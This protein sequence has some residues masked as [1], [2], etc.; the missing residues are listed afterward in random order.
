MKK[1]ILLFLMITSILSCKKENTLVRKKKTSNISFHDT[2]LRLNN[3][4]RSTTKEIYLTEN[5]AKHTLYKYFKNK[6][7]LIESELKGD[8]SELELPEYKRKKSIDFV[9]FF[10][11]NLNGKIKND[12]IISYY[13]CEPY[14]N[15]HCVQPHKAVI[16]DT[17]DGFK[18][19]NEEFLP[20]NFVIDSA[21]NENGKTFIYSY[22]FE[23]AN[24][25]IKKY[26]RI[27]IEK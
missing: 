4:E 23:C 25:K 8:F 13:N 17:K 18:I 7:Y 1:I 26:Y 11:V 12:A 20:T 16:I 6:G 27:E 5:L 3:V 24:N 15:G 9:A 2:I 21:K 10:K 14:E 22:D 19:T